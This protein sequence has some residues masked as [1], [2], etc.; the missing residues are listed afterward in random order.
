[1]GPNRGR[2]VGSSP[3]ERKYPFEIAAKMARDVKCITQD[4][5]G[6]MVTDTKYF[7]DLCND[8]TA[9]INDLKKELAIAEQTVKL[10]QVEDS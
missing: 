9:I 6:Q 4:E 1:M 3:R 8:Q 10:L 5:A 7:Y 2:W